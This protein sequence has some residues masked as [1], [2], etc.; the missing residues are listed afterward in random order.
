MNVAAMPSANRHIVDRLADV[1][2]RKKAIEAEE[3]QIAADVSKEMGSSDSLGGDDFIAKQ[4][5]SERKGALDEKKLKAKL[6]V[7]D[8]SAY[9]KAST[10]VIQ[11][12]LDRRSEDL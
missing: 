11:I 10:T 9:R 8:L 5:I 1:R 3:K 7:D 6:G 2:E 4:I 12:R